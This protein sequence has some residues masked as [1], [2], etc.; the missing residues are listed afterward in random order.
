[1]KPLEIHQRRLLEQSTSAYEQQFW[2]L[3]SSHPAKQFLAERKLTPQLARHFRLGYVDQP[4]NEDHEFFKA[5]LCIPNLIV[6]QE[7]VERPVGM[8]F[9]LLEYEGRGDHRSKF[10]SP[11]GQVA[12][13]Y[14]MRAIA[15]ATD[16]LVVTEGESDL[17]TVTMAG[18]H[19]VAA[20]GADSWGKTHRYRS[21]MMA[22]FSR[23]ILCRDSDEAGESLVRAMEDIDGLQVRE[24]G[25]HKDVTE[26]YLAEGLEALR[27]RINGKVIE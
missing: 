8:K 18:F 23:V 19:A 12:R 9:R 15:R 20:P 16:T 27:D 24:F 22:G 11:K 6:D 25:E 4:Y 10:I 3:P 7:G 21:R 14:N 5:R 2:D 1:M 17:W 26:F 13:L